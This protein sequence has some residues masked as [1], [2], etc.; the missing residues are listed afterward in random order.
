[1]RK[2]PCALTV[3]APLLILL[4][5]CGGGGSSS[6]NN[7]GGSG[8]INTSA[9]FYV[10]TN[11]N[12]SW[13]GTLAAPNSGNSDGPFATIGKAQAAVRNLV[14]SSP[15]RTS[16][17]TVM[18]RNGT[19]FVPQALSFTTADSGTPSLRII[20]QNYPGETPVIDGGERITEWTNVSGNLW[21]AALPPSTKFFEALFFNGVRRLRPRMGTSGGNAIGPYFRVFSSVTDPSGNDPNC[22]ASQAY[23]CFDRFVYSPGEP[24]SD[25]WANLNVPADPDGNPTNDIELQ[26]FERWTVP[27]MRIKTID[28]ANRIIY[29]TSSLTQDSHY[30][31]FLPNHRYII[32]NVKD[33][34][35]QPGQWFL[36]RSHTPWTLNYLAKSNEDPNT[37]VVSIPQ[38]PQVL[39]ASGLQFVTFQGITFQHD[40]WTIS[41]E[42]YVSQQQ[43]PYV[44]AAVSC[45]NCQNVV[46]D[47]DNITQTTGVGFEFVTADKHATSVNDAFQNGA[48]FDI[49]VIGIRVGHV[50]MNSDTDA[51]VPHNVVIQNNVIEGYSRVIPSGMGIVQGDGHDNLYTHNDIYDGYHAAVSICVPGCFPGQFNS[52]SAFNVTVSFNHAWN[53]MKGTTSDGGCLYFGTG[54]PN[55]TPSGNKLV[56]NKCHDVNDDRLFDTD[57]NGG[58]GM[59]LDEETG[60]VDVENNLIYRVSSYGMF[61][62]KG[63][64]QPGRA[65][66]VKNNIFAYTRDGMLGQGTP[67]PWIQGCPNTPVLMLNFSNNIMFF[68][69]KANSNGTFYVQ[70]GC[71]Y[72]CGYDYNQYQ[73]WQNNIYW[74]TDGGFK[75]DPQAFHHNT[76]PPQDPSTDCQNLPQYWSYIPFNQWQGSGNGH[77]FDEDMNSSIKDPGFTNPDPT[78]NDFTL[79]VSPG[80]GFVLF[81]VNA[82][83]RTNAVINPPTIP[84]TFLTAVHKPSDF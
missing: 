37:G 5:G 19:Y 77:T 1:V 12:D 69:R 52:H 76:V 68:D 48:L 16:P 62:S 82:P 38:S 26:V 36:D 81:D 33:A 54:N 80:N 11:G 58:H 3:A 61:L 71:A 28:T 22:P 21:Q 44:P 32:E 35:T 17:A 18:L 31:G 70:R 6:N 25:T 13:S 41:Q 8:A 43:E 72:S 45:Q 14:Q 79:N 57:G 55:F 40:D 34:L 4:A 74:R 73:N 66:S 23:V 2:I 51:N 50:N 27:K 78:M 84:D 59:Y 47:G 67:T 15:S 65:N 7:S 9:D 64:T 20:W 75:S 60:L 63:V 10:A 24:V 30:Y 56:N 83:G 42:G 39:V 49:G 46:F 29:L 53:I